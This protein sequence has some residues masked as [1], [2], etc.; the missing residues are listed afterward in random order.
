MIAP[1]MHAEVVVTFQPES[2]ADYSD[3]ILVGSTC[4][5]LHARQTILLPHPLKGS[6][7][8]C[9]ALSVCQPVHMKG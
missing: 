3:E 4:L 9:N 2:L 8:A 6:R 1:G 7:S 5:L